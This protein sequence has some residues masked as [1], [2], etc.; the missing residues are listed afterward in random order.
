MRDWGRFEGL[1][2]RKESGVFWI[3][4]K[5]LNRLSRG[6]AGSLLG[7]LGSKD[8]SAVAT[9]LLGGGGADLPALV[10]KF[11]SAGLGHLVESWIGKG[12]N[13]AVSGE[14]VKS[15][16]SPA[17]ISEVAA[18]LGIPDAQAAE[19]ISGILPGLIDKL[20]PD[21]SVPDGQTLAKKL[22]GLLK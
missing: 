3:L 11:K 7:G 14:K 2:E 16:V 21:G 22:S 18:Q 10:A 20:T 1:T 17:A 5:I 8:L 12:A 9:A 6:K 4:K 15:A 13:Q 19:K